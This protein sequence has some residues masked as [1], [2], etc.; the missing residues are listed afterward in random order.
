MKHWFGIL[1]ACLVLS[2]AKTNSNWGRPTSRE[3]NDRQTKRVSAL[4]E[5]KRQ[6]EAELKRQREAEQILLNTQ[7]AA[8]GARDEARGARNAAIAAQAA[9]GAR[10]QAIAN[11]AAAEQARLAAAAEQAR[12]AAA[13]EQARDSAQAPGGSGGESQEELTKR[14]SKRKPTDL[15]ISTIGW[16]K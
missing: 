11:A 6:R 15:L 14:M 9:I 13:A 16:F 1:C 8:Q 7:E 2:G 12:V 10:D 4:S 3:M 5:Q